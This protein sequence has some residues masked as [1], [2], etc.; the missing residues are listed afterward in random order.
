MDNRCCAVLGHDPMRF[1]WGFDEEDDRCVEFKLALI[2][3]LNDLITEEEAPFNAT[4]FAVVCD[5]GVGLYAA[6][7]VN[8]LR[9]RDSDIHLY[10]VLPYEDVATKWAPYLRK[11]HF[12]SLERCTYVT[13]FHRQKRANSQL[14]AY[15]YAIDLSDYVFAVYDPDSIRGDDVDKAIGYAQKIGR[16]I[17]MLHPDTLELT[18]LDQYKEDV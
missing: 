5:P 15:K 3:A 4:Q 9:T 7:A 14:A 10:C 18:L 2:L 8:T 6:E 1:A 17:L 11:R 13:C 16:P 12:L